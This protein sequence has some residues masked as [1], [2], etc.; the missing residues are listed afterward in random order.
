MRAQGVEP[1][2]RVMDS[3]E[4]LDRLKDKVLEEA[5]EVAAASSHDELIEELADVS[6]VLHALVRAAGISMDMVEAKRIEKKEKKGGFEERLYS[7]RVEMAADCKA[8]PYYEARLADYP[9]V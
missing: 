5:R 2:V 1:L 6:E 8:L 3:G 7:S 4:Y 9:P